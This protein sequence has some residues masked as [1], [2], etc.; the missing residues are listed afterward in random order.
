MSFQTA[1]KKFGSAGM[2]YLKCLFW[3]HF[4]GEQISCIEVIFV[5]VKTIT[6]TERTHIKYTFLK[7]YCT[8]KALQKNYTAFEVHKNSSV[9]PG[10]P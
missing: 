9:L 10:L 3:K 5:L 1:K 2:L 8:E 7:N 4:P 6:T